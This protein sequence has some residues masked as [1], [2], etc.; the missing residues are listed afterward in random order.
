MAFLRN[1]ISTIIFLLQNTSR[2]GIY[3]LRDFLI[4][5]RREQLSSQEYINYDFDLRAASFKDSFLPYAQA[6]KYWEVLNPERYSC[7]ARNKYLSHLILERAGIPT[8]KLIAYYNPAAVESNDEI[9]IDYDTLVAI[10]WKKRIS[11]FVLKPAVDGAHGHGIIVCRELI[12]T[13]GE[14]YMKKLGNEKIRLRDCLGAEP[15]LFEEIVTQ[16]AQMASFNPSSINTIRI[17]TALYPNHEVKIIA[18][19]LKI[20]RAGSDIDNAGSGGN[21]DAACCID[22]GELYHVMRFDS[23]RGYELIDFHPD[24]KIKLSGVKIENWHTIIEQVKSFQGRIPLLKTIGWDIA[25]TENGPIAIE[26]NN[27]WDTTGQLF[28]GRGWKKEVV[29]CYQAWKDHE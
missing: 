26:I 21:I 8:T 18:T 24:T 14:L 11:A 17:M 29:Q 4:L 25:L 1:K 16:T 7:L 5:H 22:T 12:E 13:N 19:F 27:Y 9:A 23:W 2:S 28:I 20:G 10:F 3:V 15:L 6:K